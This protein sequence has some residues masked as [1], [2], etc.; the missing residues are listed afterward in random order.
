V[1]VRRAAIQAQILAQVGHLAKICNNEQCWYVLGCDARGRS[2]A[3]ADE[4]PTKCG[5]LVLEQGRLVVVARAAPRRSREGLPF[6]VWMSLAKAT[7]VARLDDDAQLLLGAP[8]TR[9]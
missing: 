3:A 6:N 8:A 2:I 9:D 5:V 1:S 4:V 7:P